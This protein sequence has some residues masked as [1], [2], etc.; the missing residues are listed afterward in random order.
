MMPSSPLCVLQGDGLFWML[1]V[2]P[3]NYYGRIWQHSLRHGVSFLILTLLLLLTLLILMLTGPVSYMAWWWRWTWMWAVSFPNRSV[4]S[5][6]PV[7]PGSGSQRWSRHCVTFRGLFLPPWFLSH[8]VLWLT[9]RTFR[10]TAGTPPIHLSHFQGPVVH[11]PELQR[12]HQRSP[13][14]LSLLRRLFL[15][16]H[17]HQ[18]LLISMVRCWGPFIWDN[19][20]SWR[21]CTCYPYTYRWTHRSSLQRL[22]VSRSLGQETSPPLTGGRSL[23]EPLLRILQLMKTSL[24]TWLGLIGA[25]GQTWAEAAHDLILCFDVFMFSFYIL[26]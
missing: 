25:H 20:S 5:P 16:Q 3:G 19:S 18:H 12:Q 14:L 13:F 4:W 26:M 9:L 2:L 6:S 23:L 11:A 1:M 24:L 22:I 15:R 10:R 8:S 21:T 17:L 7:H